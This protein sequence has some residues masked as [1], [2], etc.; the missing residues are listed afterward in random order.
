MQKQYLRLMKHVRKIL[1]PFAVMYGTAVFL[2][3]KLFDSKVFSSKSYSFPVICV[4]NLNVGGTGK[5][6][7]VEYLIDLLK[8]NHR[9]AIL[10]RGYKRKSTG[11]HLLTG[12]ENSNE[13]GDEPLQFK[14][15]FMKTTVAV[16]ED[17][18][19]G[20]S[21]LCNLKPAPEVVLLDDAFQHRKVIAGLTILLT[22]YDDLYVEDFLL[23]MGGLREP[24]IGA[25]RADIIVVT[26]CPPGISLKNR[27]KIKRKLK[28]KA[29]QTVY[30]SSIAYDDMVSNGTSA[31]KLLDLG[32]F[33]L[34]TGIA[35]PAPLIE[36]LKERKLDFRHLA[37]SDHHHFT[38]PE[39]K[40]FRQCGTV[41]TTEK[42]YMRLKD[43]LP[44]EQLY[45]LPIKTKIVDNAAGFDGEIRDFV[46]L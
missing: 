46:K 18:Q 43:K 31:R 32:S 22:A 40:K 26:K 5:S 30:F 36:F 34:V 37:F 13:V 44:K 29:G 20:I 24:K 2:R 10:S 27:D 1:F 3:N 4:G 25:E 35:K 14:T 8:E 38:G 7:M 21:E 45:Y 9:I 28:P 19:H 6:P 16:D 39:L 15:K 33:T 17:R 11:F 23:P 12:R 42:D 41:L